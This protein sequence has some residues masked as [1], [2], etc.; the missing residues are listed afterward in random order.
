MA[1]WLAGAPL[2]ALVP[3]GTVHAAAGR[4]ITLGLA[5]LD[6]ELRRRFPLTRQVSGGLF[7]LTLLRPRVRLLPER[8]RLGTQLDLALTELLMGTRHAGQMDL[9]YGLRFD[10]PSRTIRLR[11]VRVHQV[12]FPTVPPPFQ[13]D[14]AR[15]A[16][17]LAEQLLEGLALHQIPR[18]Q[19]MLLDGLGFK[20]AALRVVPQ[21]LR[22]ELKPALGP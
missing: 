18:E 8:D 5:Q 13:A 7:E 19:L 17:P 6:E 11:D 10:A 16:P 14:F 15:H 2:L 1:G 22:V 12:D 4:S 3:H 21:G 9:D 20:V